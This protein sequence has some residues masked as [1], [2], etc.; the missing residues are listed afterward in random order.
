MFLYNL[1]LSSYAAIVRRVV[2]GGRLMDKLGEHS[3]IMGLP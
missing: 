1:Y 3:G 2:E